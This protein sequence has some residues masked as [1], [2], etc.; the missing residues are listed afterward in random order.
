MAGSHASAEVVAFDC[1][2]DACGR[3]CV[4]SI[5]VD[6]GKGVA[7]RTDGGADDDALLA[8]SEGIWL[9]VEHG[10]GHGWAVRTISRDEVADDWADVRMSAEGKATVIVGGGCV[11]R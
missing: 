4:T 11:E 6:L 10:V 8:P 1:A 3:A 2:R 7:A 5:V 9:K